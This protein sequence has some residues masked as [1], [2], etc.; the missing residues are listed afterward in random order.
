MKYLWSPWRKKYV[1]NHA[2]TDGCIFCRALE[3]EDGPKNLVVHRGNLAFVILNLYPYTG[4][5]IMVVPMAHQPSIVDLDD[6]TMHEIVG[7]ISQSMQVVSQVYH[8][9]G[10]NIGVNI[11]AAAGAGVVE[12]VHVHIVPRWL[13]DTNFM[14][15][16]GNSRVLPEE[17]E[18]T[19]ARLKAAWDQ[20]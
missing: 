16:V 2:G 4:G 1:L 3:Q 19:Y 15:T 6:E 11:G 9:E 13:G 10:Y 8:P 18:E 20:K 5:H 7:L 12:H 17:L 14:S